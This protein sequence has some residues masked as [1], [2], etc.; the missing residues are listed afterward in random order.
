MSTEV[1]TH[2]E[3]V[4]LEADVMALA[5]RVEALEQGGATPPDPPDYT[6]S[7]GGTTITNT[8]DYLTGRNGGQWCMAAGGATKGN[9]IEFTAY[10]DGDPTIDQGTHHAATLVY[11]TDR[12][13]WQFASNKW[14]GTDD[15]WPPA[16][17]AG[18]T[19][20][21]PGYTPPQP[22]TP[23]TNGLPSDPVGITAVRV[24]DVLEGCGANTYQN[25]QDG[26]GGAGTNTVEAHID[27]LRY[28]AGDSGLGFTLR[29]YL[30]DL[31]KQKDFCRRISEGV[32]GTKWLV[33]QNYEGQTPAVIEL[34]RYLHDAGGHCA[35][36][37]GFNEPN[38]SGLGRP[39]VSPQR[40]LQ[41]QQ[42]LWAGLRGIVPVLTA[43]L[44]ENN[45]VN[46]PGYI[47]RWYGDALPGMRDACDRWASHDYPNSGAP[48]RDMGYR[49]VGVANA[50]QKSRGF[51]TEW[52]AGLYNNHKDKETEAYWTLIGIL[53]GFKNFGSSGLQQ[54]SFYDYGDF[55]PVGLFKGHDCNNPWPVATAMRALWQ[56]TGDRGSDKRTFAPGK[57]DISFSG[58]PGGF[59]AQSGGQFLVMQSSDTGKFSVAVWNEQDRIGSA[60]S[61]VGVRFGSGAKARVVDSSLTS[62]IVEDVRPIATYTD[63][64]EFTMD[65]GTEV[66]LLEIT[67]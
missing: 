31:A 27:G 11:G 59:N 52:H 1:P 13:I 44:G 60:R 30:S 33:T 50:F 46:G 32:P 58:L 42:E 7:E 43:T 63:V 24:A 54:W 36:G 35:G 48:S 65:L 49:T 6:E 61:N 51:V 45:E 28:I 29:E 38:M 62:P 15:V 21:P 40:T 20:S 12:Q 25:G 8:G 2:D 64:T 37:E 3:F 16:W 47:E 4:A 23:P 67:L 66:R 56:R 26:S 34:C 57:L 18:T 5:E 41:Y 53:N 10:P 17:G 9:Q 19:T 55:Y 14:W 39:V 22:I